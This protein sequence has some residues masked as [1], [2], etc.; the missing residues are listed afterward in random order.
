M[1]FIWISST[2]LSIAYVS[3]RILVC[4]PDVHSGH[5]GELNMT[6]V[7]CLNL[8]ES[9]KTNNSFTVYSWCYWCTCLDGEPNLKRVCFSTWIHTMLILMS[10]KLHWVV[11]EFLLLLS[12]AHSV[13][14]PFSWL[15]LMI[16]HDTSCVLNSVSAM[17][18]F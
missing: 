18:V 7:S 3:V 1:I 12:S 9:R 2:I 6:L 13:S 16:K 17:H 11:S 15:C 8:K 4:N 14:Y 5:R 10:V